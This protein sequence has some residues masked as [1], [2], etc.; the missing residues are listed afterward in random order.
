MPEAEKKAQGQWHTVAKASK[1]GKGEMTG[2]KV[3]DTEI[4]VYNVG[5]KLCATENVCTHEFALLTDGLLEGG[6]VECPYHQG[7]F[8]VC[9]GKVVAAPPYQDLRTFPVRVTGDDIEVLIS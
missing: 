7:R 8:D 2:A 4:A 3:G 5:G 6:V 1:V 9:T